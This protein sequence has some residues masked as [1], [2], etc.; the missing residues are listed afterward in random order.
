VSVKFLKLTSVFVHKFE[1][2]G[3]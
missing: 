3:I 2:I 1:T